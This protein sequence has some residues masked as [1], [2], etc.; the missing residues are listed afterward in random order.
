MHY[1]DQ[2]LPWEDHRTDLPFVVWT[3]GAGAGGALYRI[4]MTRYVGD[5]VAGNLE[6]H[7]EASA[8]SLRNPVSA[9]VTRNWLVASDTQKA[10]MTHFAYQDLLHQYLQGQLNDGYD[11][12]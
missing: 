5:E 3:G 11:G 7:F 9:M 8:D 6:L 1:I 10:E 2:L 12:A 4:V